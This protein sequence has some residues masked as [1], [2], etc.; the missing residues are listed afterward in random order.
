MYF[1]GVFLPRKTFIS[2]LRLEIT[3]FRR[4]V[5]TSH[6]TTPHYAQDYWWHVFML[7][8]TIVPCTLLC[9]YCQNVEH[10]GNINI[11]SNNTDF[12]ENNLCWQVVKAAKRNS[13]GITVLLR[14]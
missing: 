12:I 13:G 14:K 11:L 3:H 2:F 5:S 6:I 9:N 7:V 1:P 4:A 8:L 10:C